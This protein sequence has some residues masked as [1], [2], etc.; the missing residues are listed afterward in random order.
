[1]SLGDGVFLS[2]VTSSHS[3]PVNEASAEPTFFAKRRLAVSAHIAGNIFWKPW[4]W[5]FDFD[6]GPR[7]QNTR[8]GAHNPL[9]P[10]FH[11]TNLES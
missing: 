4:P 5:D 6:F 8:T 2:R 11:V 3:R 1:M 7:L 10:S 9:R